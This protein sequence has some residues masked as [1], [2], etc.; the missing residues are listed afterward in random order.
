M[1]SCAILI[2]VTKK[3]I[4][5]IKY[6][7]MISND[8]SRYYRNILTFLY[9]CQK[10]LRFSTYFKILKTVKR[11]FKPLEKVIPTRFFLNLSYWN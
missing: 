10:H 9:D 1:N 6:L 2:I 3:R 11:F 8:I 5:L 7:M 4:I